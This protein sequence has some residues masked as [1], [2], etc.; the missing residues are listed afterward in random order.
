ADKFGVPWMVLSQNA[1]GGSTHLI[2][3][4]KRHLDDAEPVIGFGF[5]FQD[6]PTAAEDL[7]FQNDGMLAA[8]V[9]VGDVFPRAQRLDGHKLGG[10][11]M[12][13]FHPRHRRRTDLARGRFSHANARN[14]ATNPTCRYAVFG[15]FT[16]IPMPDRP[17]WRPVTLGV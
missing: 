1:A 17:S 10:F 16:P 7:G 4:G 5:E 9:D 6:D 14:T 15:G 2:T 11:Q 3:G 8:T 13:W 12:V